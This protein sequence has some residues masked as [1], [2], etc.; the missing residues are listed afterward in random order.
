MGNA[1]IMKHPAQ[2]N[3]MPT[4]QIQNLKTQRAC[5]ARVTILG[6]SVRPFVCLSVY[7]YSRITG[8]EAVYT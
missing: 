6:Q 5:T 8:Y 7:A 1:A 3:T 4:T 2:N